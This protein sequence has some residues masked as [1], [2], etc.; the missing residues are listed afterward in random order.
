VSAGERVTIQ[1]TCYYCVS[2]ISSRLP[3]INSSSHVVHLSPLV[4]PFQPSHA[5][6][7][8]PQMLIGASIISIPASSTY[9]FHGEGCV[10]PFVALSIGAYIHIAQRFQTGAASARG[11]ISHHSRPG[12]SPQERTK[13][14]SASQSHC[15]RRLCVVAL[16]ANSLQLAGGVNRWEPKETLLCNDDIEGHGRFWR[17]LKCGKPM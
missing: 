8:L 17:S 3:H 10:Q 15:D 5:N 14:S 2:Q 16:Q 12:Y 6:D 11:C 1:V 7:P 9:T 13:P 4:L